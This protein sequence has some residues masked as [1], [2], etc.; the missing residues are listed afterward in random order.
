MYFMNRQSDAVR[1][2]EIT[3]E[4]AACFDNITIP[5][6][7]D[8]V[9]VL[10]GENGTGKT[11]TLN[12]IVGV[13]INLVFSSL[14]RIKALKRSLPFSQ[15]KN[16]TD[17]MLELM[18]FHPGSKNLNQKSRIILRTTF[19]YNNVDLNLSYQGKKDAFHHPTATINIDNV[20]TN[21]T[22]KMIPISRARLIEDKKIQGPNETDAERIPFAISPDSQEGL[23]RIISNLRNLIRNTKEFRSEDLKQWIINHDYENLKKKEEGKEDLSFQHFKEKLAELMPEN[24]KISLKRITKMEPVFETRTGETPFGALSSGFQSILAIYW[25]ILYHLQA[26]YPNSENPFIESATVLI[27]EIEASLHPEWQQVIIK[28]LRE[29]FPNV[30]F[31]IATQSPLVISSCGEGEVVFLKFD[32]EHK[33]VVIDESAPKNPSGWLV[34]TLLTGPMGLETARGMEMGEEIEKLKSIIMRSGIKPPTD[35]EMKEIDEIVSRLDLP[36]E[37]PVRPLLELNEMKR[38]MVR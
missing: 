33:T 7:P 36:A 26:Y 1:I 17:E 19:N 28:G 16:E 9:T 32:D 14:L 6:N 25:N 2:K 31:I 30:Q 37:D 29:L 34:E 38:K 20:P 4:N 18:N 22:L 12:A 23:S 11:T 8:G 24:Q 27:D 15:S 3:I 13:L 35:E 10:V 21:F 5:F